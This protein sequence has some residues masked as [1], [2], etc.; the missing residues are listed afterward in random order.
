MAEKSL[1]WRTAGIGWASP[2][3]VLWVGHNL[4]ERATLLL[5]RYIEGS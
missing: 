5:A 1:N 2:G 3:H 4:E